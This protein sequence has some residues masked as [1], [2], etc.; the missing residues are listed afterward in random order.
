M[1]NLYV[2]SL[3]SLAWA[4]IVSLLFIAICARSADV[5]ASWCP[6]NTDMPC[7]ATR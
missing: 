6:I 2:K 1:G 5:N 3:R 7:A 4:A